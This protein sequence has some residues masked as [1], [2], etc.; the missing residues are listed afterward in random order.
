MKLDIFDFG[1]HYRV[2]LSQNKLVLPSNVL[3]RLKFCKKEATSF[4]RKYDLTLQI[5]ILLLTFPLRL[6]D[7]LYLN[8]C[9]KLKLCKI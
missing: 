1:I 6:N 2:S 9:T 8:R 7:Y 3:Y 4:E 5:I